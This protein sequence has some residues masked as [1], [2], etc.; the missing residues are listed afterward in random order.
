[1]QA[2]PLLR[3]GI[4]ARCLNTPHIRGMGKYASEL[5]KNADALAKVEWRFFADRPDTVFHKPVESGEIE[6][7]DLKG[8]RFNTWEQI[9]L[10]W[11]ARRAGIDILHCIATT[12][13][14]WQAV[15]TIVTIHDTLM[16]KEDELHLSYN[17]W[18]LHHLIPAAFKRCTAI[19]TISESS[20]R[21]ILELWP[22]LERKL[23]VIPHGVS[24]IYLN[25]QSKILSPTFLDKVGPAP[26]FLYIGG[27]L[28]RKR[29]G[30]A[31]KVLVNIDIP[32]IRLLVCGFSEAE[33]TQARQ[34]IE[35]SL[36]DRIVFLPFI[37]ETYMAQLY[38]QAVAVLY[39]T[40]Y[41]GFGFPALEAQAVG[42]PVLFSAL[43]SLIELIGPSAEILPPEN[44]D[45]WV[46]TCQRLFYQRGEF[47]MRI[48]NKDAREWAQ[49][50]SW[51]VSSTR[52]LELYR[53]VAEQTRSL[54]KSRFF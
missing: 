51:K 4:D 5:I 20:R 49:Q 14:Y 31:I 46:K 33:R 3:L 27:S 35:P 15:P 23:H 52:H 34:N 48:P 43:G 24:D 53:K 6:L 8:Y 32:K 47:N 2:E 12:L 22:Y 13:P 10:P 54:L 7:F 36:R 18:Y 40:L 42:T 26:Y 21:D 37:E 50:F 29:F 16:W 17:K 1:M 9:G 45:A 39:P 19:I 25:E 11:Q 38:Q 41:E 28:A 30:W 44:L